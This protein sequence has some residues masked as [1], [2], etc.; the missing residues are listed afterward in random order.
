MST[1]VGARNLE[2]SW[3]ALSQGVEESAVPEAPVPAPVAVGVVPEVVRI[4]ATA[5]LVAALV[6]R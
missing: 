3:K 4:L 1:P 2:I 5:L 6:G